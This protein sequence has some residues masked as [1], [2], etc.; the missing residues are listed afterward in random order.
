M[1]MKIKNAILEVLSENQSLK[2]EVLWREVRFRTGMS[3]LDDNF[4]RNLVREMKVE[5]GV[6]IGSS[7]ERG[8]FLIK[9]QNDFNEA[10]ECYQKKIAG[11]FRIIKKI[12]ENV[13][14]ANGIQLVLPLDFN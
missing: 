6:P 7:V 14:R 8:Y 9:D 10:I 2:R 1:K 13:E 3:E 11:M 12:K 4:L 5:D